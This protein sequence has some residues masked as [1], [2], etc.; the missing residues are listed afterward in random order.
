[1]NVFDDIIP[2]DEENSMDRPIA[3]NISDDL[4]QE[5]IIDFHA[6]QPEIADD[7]ANDIVSVA[8]SPLD[9]DDMATLRLSVLTQKPC[10]S[11]DEASWMATFRPDPDNIK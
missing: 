9:K 11:D 8:P 10:I 4:S 1:M 2:E 3:L 7:A 5:T 6:S